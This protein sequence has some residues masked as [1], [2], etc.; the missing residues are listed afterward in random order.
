MDYVHHT[1]KEGLGN[2]AEDGK[3]FAAVAYHKFRRG[4]DN[5]SVAVMSDSIMEIQME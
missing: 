3:S 5:E 2:V 4:G 1:G